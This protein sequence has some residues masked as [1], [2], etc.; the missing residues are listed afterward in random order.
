[1]SYWIKHI[2]NKLIFFNKLSD[3]YE[4][5]KFLSLVFLILI[6]GIFIHLTTNMTGLF[7]GIG[8]LF[9]VS[10]WAIFRMLVNDDKIKIDFS[11]YDIPNEGEIIQFIKKQTFNSFSYPIIQRTTSGGVYMKMKVYINESDE[12]RVRRVIQRPDDI[13]LEIVN[14]ND[15]SDDCLIS[16]LET[17]KN[18]KT[19]RD[20]RNIKISQILK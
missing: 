6:S 10:C 3:R 2:T 13:T 19:K 9:I 15:E 7:C 20:I 8:I 11:I 12:Y 5:A 18:W 17:R 4:T 14:V 16:F 1:M